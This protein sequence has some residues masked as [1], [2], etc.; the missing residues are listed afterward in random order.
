LTHFLILLSEI[1]VYGVMTHAD[2]QGSNER[3]QQFKNHL[4]LI[5]TRFKC[6]TNYCTDFDPNESYISTTLP[7]LDIPVL[8][9]MTQVSFSIVS[10]PDEGYSKNA[11][12]ALNLIST[13]L[14]VF[15]ECFMHSSQLNYIIHICNH[16][17]ASWKILNVFEWKHTYNQGH[18]PQSISITHLTSLQITQLFLTLR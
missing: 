10:V 6:I 13:F 5:N 4:G 11:S 9:L 14:I 18:S 15:N 16:M 7:Q 17:V 3:Q 1:P 2:K 12:P 8:K